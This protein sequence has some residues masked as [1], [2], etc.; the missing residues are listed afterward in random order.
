MADSLDRRAHDLL[1]EVNEIV[2][3][4]RIVD[5][6]AANGPHAELS[7]Q[8]LKVIEFLGHLGPRMMR[9]LAEVLL[10][11]VN[12]VTSTIDNLERKELVRRNRS[13]EDRRIVR[14]ELTPKGE[15]AYAGALEE[16]LR[17]MRSM[18]S[19]L[20]DDEQEIFMVLMRKIARAVHQPAPAI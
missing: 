6:V 17:L 3:Q 12:S 20:T 15:E 7:M 13:D 4:F 8:E 11:A 18:L 10:V 14:V 1:Q 9:E 2:H 19:S 5:S 16:K